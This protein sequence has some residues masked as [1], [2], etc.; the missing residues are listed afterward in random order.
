M[1]SRTLPIAGLMIVA[2]CA[3]A[4]AAFSRPS[5]ARVTF[6]AVGPAGLKIEGST[7]E[8]DVSEDS[9]SVMVTV[10]L[11]NLQTGID[12]R[13]RHMRE[14]YLEVEKYPQARL[15]IARSSLKL[16]QPGAQLKSEAEGT[17]SLH[18]ASG[19]RLPSTK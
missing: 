16:P 14:K 9:E 15:I 7:T 19:P 5:D 6:H 12:M 8:L 2:L 4:A 10:A 11:G 13:D 1:S 17:L 18:G 3:T